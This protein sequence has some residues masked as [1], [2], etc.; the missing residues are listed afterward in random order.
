MEESQT[1][2]FKSSWRDEYLKCICAF[3]NTECNDKE[4]SER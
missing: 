1:I 4:K 2:E 3:A